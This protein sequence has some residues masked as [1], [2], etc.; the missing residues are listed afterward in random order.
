MIKKKIIRKEKKLSTPP[1]LVDYQKTYREYT[2]KE[3]E[4]EIARKEN[5]K[6]Q[7]S[8]Y[9]DLVTIESKITIK[10]SKKKD[11]K[12][13]VNRVVEGELLN[14]SHK[15]NVNYLNIYKVQNKTNKIEWETDL[16][17]EESKEIKYK[18]S[19]YIRR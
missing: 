4:K 17:A 7:D 12:L 8:S 18:Y 2:W 14:S 10:N 6:L 9:F 19:I 11:I 1:N 13:N 3:A 15:W 16:K 5:I